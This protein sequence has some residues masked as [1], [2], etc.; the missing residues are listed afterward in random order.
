MGI[1][2]SKTQKTNIITLTLL[3]TCSLSM[4]EIVEKVNINAFAVAR[5]HIQGLPLKSQHLS[6]VPHHDL[7]KMYQAVF[8]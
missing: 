1:L 7:A 8:I 3:E 6:Q 4:L 2:I 5:N